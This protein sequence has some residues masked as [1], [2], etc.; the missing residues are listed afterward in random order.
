LQYN[1]EYFFTIFSSNCAGS[2]AV[3]TTT[4]VISKLYLCTYVC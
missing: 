2:S 3:F 1:I 4:V